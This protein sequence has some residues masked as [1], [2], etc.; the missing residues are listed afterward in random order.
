MKKRRREKGKKKLER[1]IVSKFFPSFPLVPNT[2]PQQEYLFGTYRK[3]RKS[4]KNQKK[5]PLVVW[6][7]KKEKGKY[8]K[9]KTF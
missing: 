1:K 5:F 6:F 2:H 3:E 4:K 8:K 9:K 7:R